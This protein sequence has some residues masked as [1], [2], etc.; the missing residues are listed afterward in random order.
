MQY[1]GGHDPN[2]PS[3]IARACHA[4]LAS[5]C[6]LPSSR[7]GPQASVAHQLEPLLRILDLA[8][9]RAGVDDGVEG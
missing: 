8:L 3:N 7:F 4:I 2:H 6:A 1:L 9:L 5:L